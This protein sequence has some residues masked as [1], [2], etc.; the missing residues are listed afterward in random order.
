MQLIKTHHEKPTLFLSLASEGMGHATRAR[1]LIQHL[2]HVYDLHVFCGGKVY[3]YLKDFHHQVHEIPYVKLSYRNNRMSLW[4]TVRS[5]APKVVSFLRRIFQMAR[6]TRRLKPVALISD[7]EFISSW[8]ALLSGV[9]VISFDNMHLHPYAELDDPNPENQKAAKMVRRICRVNLPIK[10]KVLVSSFFTPT[11]K[12][13]VC[14]D[15]FRYIPCSVRDEV[16]LRKN[17]VSND[18]PVLVYQT[19]QSNNDLHETLERAVAETQLSFTVYGSS[20]KGTAAG[21]RIH[22]RPFDDTAFLDDMAAAPFVMINGG[23]SAICEALSLGKPILA[24]PIQAQYE[25]ILNGIYLEKLGVGLGVQKLTAAHIKH[26]ESCVP[27]MQRR[28]AQLDVVDT[29]GMIREIR[30]A[31]EELS[32]SGKVPRRMGQKSRLLSPMGTRALAGLGRR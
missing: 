1:T 2:G 24:E 7:F 21:G 14:E 12:Q 5:E 25:Q 11:L 13:H 20:G 18:G 26:F 19:S 8:S 17:K 9:K 31:I 3:R 4:A 29:E 27:L 6:L 30:R 15:F 23:H 28:A 10:H 32:P 16:L 22:Y